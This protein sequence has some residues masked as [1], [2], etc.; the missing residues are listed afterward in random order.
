MPAA[1]L[2]DIQ[3]KVENNERLNRDEALRLFASNDLHFLG[4]LARLIKQRKTGRYV[5]F[6]VNRHINLTNICVSRCKF[7]AFGVDRDAPQAYTM[8]LEEVLRVAEESIPQ[9]VTELHIVSALHPDLPF[10]Y[11]LEIIQELHRRWPQVHLQAFTAVEIDYFAKISG[12]SIE[13]V[14]VKLKEAGLGSMPGGGAEIL[15]P[16]VRQLTCPRKASTERWLEVMRTAHGLGVRTNATMLYGHIET[17]EER[18]DHLLRLRELQDETGGFQSFI[19]LAFH[20]ENTALAD[21]PRTTAFDDLKV[22]TISRLL[23][24][25]FDHVKAFW[26]MLGVPLAQLSLEFG[27]D[28]LDGTVVEE[29]ITHAA[30]AKTA[31]GITKSELIRLIRE[32]GYIPVE[33][34]TV[35][36]VLQIYDQEEKQCVP[37]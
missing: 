18:V 1:N 23:L 11:Y 6:N 15:S 12:L 24:D 2:V 20:P 35:Y 29:K 9:G 16:R 28:D 25:N 21:V 19:P 14:L 32:A 34:D 22:I 13:Q 26:I 5:Y 10:E 33:R 27:V 31:P 4:E 30:G 17:I 3:A 7:C 37:V 36:N 8:S